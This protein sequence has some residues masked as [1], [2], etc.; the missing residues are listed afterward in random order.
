MN[1]LVYVKHS[2]EC[3]FGGHLISRNILLRKRKKF[4]HTP[5]KWERNYAYS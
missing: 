2:K 1:S 5:Q 4:M 3:V